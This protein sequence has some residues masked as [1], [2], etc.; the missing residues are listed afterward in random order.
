[1]DLDEVVGGGEGVENLNGLGEG[2]VADSEWSGQVVHHPAPTH[3]QRCQ[4]ELSQ[5]SN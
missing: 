5:R 2:D 3:K 1:M 4:N